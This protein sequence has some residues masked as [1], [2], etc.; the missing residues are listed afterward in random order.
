MWEQREAETVNLVFNR[1]RIQKYVTRGLPRI[2]SSIVIPEE[3]GPESYDNYDS[4]VGGDA[5]DGGSVILGSL[6]IAYEA[7][8]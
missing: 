5:Q 2:V 4:D 7:E 8:G 3:R 6:A 1:I